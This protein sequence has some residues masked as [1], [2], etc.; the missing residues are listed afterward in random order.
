[1]YPPLLLIIITTPVF[2]FSSVRLS[3][4]CNPIFIFSNRKG[5]NDNM[6]GQH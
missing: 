6:K 4:T 3:T 1:M 5:S 2:L